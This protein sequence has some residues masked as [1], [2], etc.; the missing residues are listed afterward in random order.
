VRTVWR[1]PY[2]VGDEEVRGDRG[3]AA[4]DGLCLCALIEGLH[5]VCA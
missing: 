3:W 1:G 5:A 2:S 4:P